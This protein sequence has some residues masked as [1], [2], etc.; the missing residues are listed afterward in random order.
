VSE[1][2]YDVALICENGHVITTT[3]R[4][5][6]QHGRKFCEQCGAATMSACKACQHPIRGYYY[7]GV[8]GGD[9]YRRPSYCAECAAP[10]PWTQT[11]IE[12]FKALTALAEGLSN[13][14]RRQLDAAINDIMADTPRTSGAVARI[15][16]LG[17][18]VGPE[19][20]DGLKRIAVEVAS[21]AA[22]KQLGV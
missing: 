10:Y 4:K 8:I 3:A 14:Q 16:L 20:W 12:E 2:T 5:Y 21:E 13:E 22:K 18:K 19:L 7:S 15:K 11:A 17:P 9:R 1:G 6:P